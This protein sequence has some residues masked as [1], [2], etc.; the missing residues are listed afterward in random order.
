M[1]LRYKPDKEE[2]PKKP[3]VPPAINIPK[4]EV[5]GYKCVEYKLCNPFDIEC[6]PCVTAEDKFR[7]GFRF[8][9]KRN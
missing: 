8:M 9:Q 3:K 4:A 6:D 5:S 1:A 2:E 7:S